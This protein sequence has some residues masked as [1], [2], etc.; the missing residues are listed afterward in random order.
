MQYKAIIDI[1]WPITADMT[2]YKDRKLV[3]V[4][5]TKT[6]EK[7][8][9]RE[10]VVTIGTHSGTH[11]DA[12]AHFVAT[13]HTIDQLNLSLLVGRCRVLDLTHCVERITVD[14]LAVHGIQAGERILCKTCNSQEDP[15]APFNPSFVFIDDAA[16]AYLVTR[17][18]AAVG[19]DYLGIERQQPEHQTHQQLLEAGIAII[20]GLRL[21]SV[22]PGLYDLICLPM[23]MNGLDAAPARAI[24]LQY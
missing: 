20:E 6:F 21:A 18:V 7:D 15:T 14:D 9:V 24:L 8:Q 16:S 1:S 10:A 23:L 5:K 13:G 3:V 19:I 17:K 2:A 4:N 12:P 11:V 22:P